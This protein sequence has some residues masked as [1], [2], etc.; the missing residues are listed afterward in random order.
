MT[1]WTSD[2]M[3]RVTI[4]PLCSTAIRSAF[5][6]SA[7]ITRDNKDGELRASR[8]RCWPLSWMVRGVGIRFQASRWGHSVAS[9]VDLALFYAQIDVPI[10]VSECNEGA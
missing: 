4:S 2:Q 9:G 8:V 5:S 3:V 1:I 7:L 6:S 10:S